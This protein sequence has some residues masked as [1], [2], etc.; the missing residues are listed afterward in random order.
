VP[1]FCIGTAAT[2]SSVAHGTSPLTG[3]SSSEVAA[4]ASAGRR[5]SVTAAGGLPRYEITPEIIARKTLQTHRNDC[6]P[7][8]RKR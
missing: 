6:G 2:V 3:G 5:F 7:D 8:R 4:K 1:Q